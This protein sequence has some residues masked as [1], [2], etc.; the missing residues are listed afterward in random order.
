M[1]SGWY[2][3]HLL[4]VLHIEFQDS[5]YCL[6]ESLSKQNKRT[7]TKKTQTDKHKDVWNR[8]GTQ[9]WRS[10]SHMIWVRSHS[11]LLTESVVRIGY[12]V[13]CWKTEEEKEETIKKLLIL[14]Q[15]F[16]FPPQS[17]VF[18]SYLPKTV[19]SPNKIHTSLCKQRWVCFF[20]LC[21]F[22]VV[23]QTTPG[24]LLPC[25]I[26]LPRVCPCSLQH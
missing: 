3:I 22:Y 18:T 16:L 23:L 24:Y 9:H 14:G 19:F 26:W 25:L 15:S 4:A 11:Q 12:K 7:I 8:A 21:T 17:T 13:L 5:K 10:R 6:R 20:S 1:T 2:P